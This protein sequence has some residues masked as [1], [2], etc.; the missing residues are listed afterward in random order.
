MRD[1]R[2]RRTR[3]HL[4]AASLASLRAKAGDEAGVT[5]IEYAFIAGLVAIVVVG[6]VTTLGTGVSSLFNSV[7]GGF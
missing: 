5:A 1:R 4:A 7:L 3:N 6:A 2:R